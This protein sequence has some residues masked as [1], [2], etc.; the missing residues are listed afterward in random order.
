MATIMIESI[1][2]IALY[3]IINWAAIELPLLAALAW[4][5][6]RF[7]GGRATRMNGEQGVAHAPAPLCALRAAAPR[8]CRSPGT[9]PPALDVTDP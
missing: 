1:V 2:T 4:S 5:A 6:L 9:G 3:M 8:A 7:P